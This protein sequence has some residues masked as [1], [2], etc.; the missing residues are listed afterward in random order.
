MSV[1]FGRWSFDGEPLTPQYLDGV[2]AIIDPY[3]PDGGDSYFSKGANILYHSFHTTLESRQETQPFLSRS[4]LVITW[5][6]RLDNRLELIREC[7]EALPQNPPDALIVGAAYEQWATGCLAKLIGDWALSIWNPNERCLILA[8][9]TLGVRPLYYS[10][11]K[12]R[13]TWST[14]LDPLVLFSG[15]QFTLDEGYIAGWLSSF[16]AADLTPYADIHSVPPSSFVRLTPESRI[17]RQY[18]DFDPAKRIKYPT[19]AEYEEHFRAVFAESL[20]RRLRSDSPILAELSGG[21]D[22]SSIVCMADAVIARGGAGT[23]RLDT[24]SYYNDSESNWNERP[25]FTKVE[26]KRGRA[27]HHIDIGSDDSCACGADVEDNRFVA[28]PGSAGRHATKSAREYVACLASSGYRAVLSGIGGDE[29]T[30]GVPSPGPE[31]ADLLV[32]ARVQELAHK[33]KVWA[34]IKRRPWFHLLLETVRPFFSPNLLAIPVHRR[35]APWIEA[36]FIG[37]NHAALTGSQ[38]RL[39]VLGSLPTFQENL[40]ALNSLRRQL[41]CSALP[42]EPAYDKRYPFLDRDLLEFLFAVP[43]EQILRPG[44]RRSLLRR[45]LAGIVPDEI[46]NRK[47][48]AYVVRSALVAVSSGWDRLAAT[49][50]TMISSALGIVDQAKVLEALE[51][52]KRGHEVQIVILLRTIAIEAWLR[53]LDSRGLLYSRAQ[54]T[55]LLHRQPLSNIAG[56]KELS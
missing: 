27:G 54:T 45:A 4:G 30:G 34:L 50:H 31:L 33:L 56:Q 19:D 14:I 42:S 36:S 12:N 46:L 15:R 3:A 22:S 32:R 5:D 48:K 6:G 2:R 52:T 21:M 17:V 51:T 25:Y 41:G 35:P 49:R 39:R 29:V 53:A 7:K 38:S 55:A 8:K 10:I 9:D 24:L 23:P 16:P 18:W 13:I 1:M 44:Q 26:E 47:R 43:R 37:R 11:E 20:R 28:V 40:N